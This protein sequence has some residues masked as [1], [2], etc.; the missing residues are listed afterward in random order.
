MVALKL[1]GIVRAYSLTDYTKL[2]ISSSTLLVFCDKEYQKE[3][4]SIPY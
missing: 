2:W 4:V 1:I 3:N